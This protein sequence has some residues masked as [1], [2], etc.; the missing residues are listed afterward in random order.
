MIAKELTWLEAQGRHD[1]QYNPLPLDNLNSNIVCKDALINPDGSLTQWPECDAI[2][3]NPP[4]QSKNKMQ[5]EF[6]VEYLSKLRAA[7]PYIAK[8]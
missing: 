4:Y 7:Y 3:G 6:G 5:K 2:I 8:K 1:R